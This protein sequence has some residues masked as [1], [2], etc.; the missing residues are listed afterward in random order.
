MKYSIDWLK[1]KFEREEKLKYLFFWGHQESKN[2]IIT[3]SCFS[4]WWLSPFMIENIT[5]MTAEH[6]MMA[7][8]ALLFNDLDIYNKILYSKS[9]GEAKDLGRNV[10]NF[11][12]KK[13]N[14]NRYEIVVKGNTYKFS[15]NK[16]LK[17]FLIGT[18]ERILVEASPIDRVWGIGLTANSEKAENPKLWNGL[19]LLGF[20]LME[21]RDLLSE[22]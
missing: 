12:E 6:W 19:N 17:E 20:A 5:Y 9:P 22:D 3:A 15:Q 1:E 11:D 21:V 8:K 14:D 13:W 10:K 7:Q 18:K 2:G 16:K 4:Q